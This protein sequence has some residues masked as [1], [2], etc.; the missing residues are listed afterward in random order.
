M[1]I[2]IPPEHCKWWAVNPAVVLYVD[3]IIMPSSEFE[4][5]RE[6][7]NQNTYH[8][9]VYKTV[10]LLKE[11]GILET[12]D[13]YFSKDEEIISNFKRQV[14]TIIEELDKEKLLQVIRDLCSAYE[15][16]IKYNEKKLEIL[17]KSLKKDYKYS[18]AILKDMNIWHE[19]LKFLRGIERLLEENEK[20]VGSERIDRLKEIFSITLSNILTHVYVMLENAKLHQGSAFESLREYKPF[21]KYIDPN[22]QKNIRFLN[23]QFL[24]IKF[25]IVGIKQKNF[26]Q[27]IIDT[28]GAYLK[29]RQILKR[30]EDIGWDLWQISDRYNTDKFEKELLKFEKEL[31]ERIKKE[32]SPYK[33]IEDKLGILDSMSLMLGALG[34]VSIPF[35]QMIS[36]MSLF[37]AL[38][39][40]IIAETLKLLSIK[41][42]L[43]TMNMG[44]SEVGFKNLSVFFSL[45]DGVTIPTLLSK[46]ERLLSKDDDLIKVYVPIHWRSSDKKE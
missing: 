5:I 7:R 33:R 30:L 10:T 22:N 25:P 24:V 13:L 21:V 45:L 3:S 8:A 42:A 28:V 35:N 16:W 32:I 19:D 46:K 1:R 40:E 27:E 4:K 6:G 36:G 31:L 39:K 12:S 26:L 17:D 11:E 14:E 38:G 37:L 2:V 29:I 41:D 18:E 15:Y 34:F 23:D 43:E 9:L 20:E 44:E